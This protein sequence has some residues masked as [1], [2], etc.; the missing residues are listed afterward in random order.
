MYR[1]KIEP[2]RND[3]D[4]VTARKLLQ[5]SLD[6]DDISS[7]VAFSSTI[8]KLVKTSTEVGLKTGDL[9]LMS[10]VI[11]FVPMMVRDSADYLRAQGLDHESVGTMR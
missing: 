10:T 6:R 11:T 4:L 7:A 9:L 2:S 8:L 1:T 3:S 5:L